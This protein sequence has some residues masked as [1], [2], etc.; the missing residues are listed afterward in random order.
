MEQ[1]PVNG[2]KVKIEDPLD[3]EKTITLNE[4][5]LR[6]SDSNQLLYPAPFEEIDDIYDHCKIADKIYLNR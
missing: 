3:S 4:L 5:Y 6:I 2:D 1:L